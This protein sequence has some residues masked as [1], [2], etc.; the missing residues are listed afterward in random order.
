[1]FREAVVLGEVLGCL[2]L[3]DFKTKSCQTWSSV[4]NSLRPKAR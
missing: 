4:G 3:E 2:V 1:M